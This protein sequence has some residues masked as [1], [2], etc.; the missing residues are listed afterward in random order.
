[1][2]DGGKC[3]GASQNTSKVTCP[4][5]TQVQAIWHVQSRADKQLP[6][7]WWCKADK[8]LAFGRAAGCE[9]K[10]PPAKMLLAQSILEKQGLTRRNCPMPQASKSPSGFVTKKAVPPKAAWATPGTTPSVGSF[11]LLG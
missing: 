3:S 7:F 4:S 2:Q 11:C 8:I 9:Q 5:R 10:P 1:M 6:F